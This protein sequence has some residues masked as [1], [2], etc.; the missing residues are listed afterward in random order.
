MIKDYYKILGLERTAS[1]KEIK[2]AYLDLARKYHP[3]RNQDSDSALEK[4]NEINEA[5]ATLGDLDNRLIYSQKLYR[6]D[7]IKQ[8]AKKKFLKLKKSRENGK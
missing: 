7:E 4:F 2:K 1:A 6:H 8:E 3:D 5:Y